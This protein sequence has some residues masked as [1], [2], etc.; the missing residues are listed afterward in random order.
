MKKIHIL[1]FCSIFVST[2]LGQVTLTFRNNG[3]VPGDS[4]RTQEITYIDPGNAGE[5]QLWDFSGIRNTSKTT[6]CGVK[7]D[8]AFSVKDNG[9]SGMI[10]SEDGYDHTLISSENEY[11]ETGYINTARHQTMVCSDPVVKMKY[12]F[13]FGRTFSDAFT[14]VESYN[15]KNKVSQEGTY[16]VTADAYGTLILPDRIL[17]NTLRLKT[18]MQSLHTGKCGS[19]QSLVVKYYW[20]APG[21]RYPVLMTGTTENKYGIKD[22]VIFKHAWLNLDQRSFGSPAED[23]GVNSQPGPEGNAVIVFPNPFGEQATYH[24]FIREQVPVMVELYDM[25]GKFSICVEK[26]QLRTEGLHTGTIRPADLGLTPGIY[27][28]RFTLDK[29]VVV[30][31]V[32]KI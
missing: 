31:K 1:L 32:V 8:P 9:G 12:P 14:G 22:P 4:S 21:Y 2:V 25:S 11:E 23:A 26:K 30:D 20:Y 7:S 24:Y 16:S 15:E 5:N 27:Y 13:P 28:L 6:Y 3:L 17:K 19:T 18:V 10:L 29:E